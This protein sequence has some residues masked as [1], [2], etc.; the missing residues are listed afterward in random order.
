MNKPTGPKPDLREGNPRR[1]GLHKGTVLQPLGL[2]RGFNALELEKRCCGIDPIGN[3]F[4]QYGY[5]LET[6]CPTG[7]QSVSN[8][9]QEELDGEKSGEQDV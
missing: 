8:A 1:N 3:W 2:G 5:T 6:T 4:S 7:L 9:I